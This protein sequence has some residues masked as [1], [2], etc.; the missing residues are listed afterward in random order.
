MTC[1]TTE[2]AIL[3]VESS[4]IGQLVL[5]LSSVNFDF[6]ICLSF[7]AS[8]LDQEAPPHRLAVRVRVRLDPIAT[9]AR[10]DRLKIVFT[11][12]NYRLVFKKL[13]YEKHSNALERYW[14]FGSRVPR[15]SRSWSINWKKKL[16]KRSI[17][18]MEGMISPREDEMSTKHADLNTY[19]WI[20][21]L[22]K[23]TFKSH[24]GSTKNS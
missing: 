2:R 1:L 14:T 19:N 3:L 22:W 5:C 12:L 7:F 18:W 8:C 23:C 9:V 4:F 16:R 24:L 11:S 20:Q 21:I 10:K 6:S 15:V 17:K 13:T